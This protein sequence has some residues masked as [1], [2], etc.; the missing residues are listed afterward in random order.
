[1]SENKNTIGYE[2]LQKIFDHFDVNFHFVAK[3]FTSSFKGITTHWYKQNS[4]NDRKKIYIE[5]FLS[6]T[7]RQDGL[8]EEL[9]KMCNQ[10]WEKIKETGIL[11]REEL[12]IPNSGSALVLYE[13]VEHPDKNTKYLEFDIGPQ[14]DA[15]YVYIATFFKKAYFTEMK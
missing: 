11:V 10:I 6:N 14:K 12:Q 9:E 4:K 8:Y 7:W 5:L 3:N 2:D 15:K 1:M 13:F